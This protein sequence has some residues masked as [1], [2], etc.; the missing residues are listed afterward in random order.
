MATGF[1]PL[2]LFDDRYRICQATID[3]IEAG[4]R[5]IDTAHIYLTED[6]VGKAIDNVTCRGIVKREE[7]FI[8]TKLGRNNHDNLEMWK[9]LEDAQRLGLTKSIG[10]SN[11]NSTYMARILANSKTL[12]AVNQ[13]ETNPTFANLELVAYCQS[14]NIVVTGY[15]PF[16]FLVRRVLNDL[17]FPPTFDDPLLVRLAKKYGVTVSQIV[18][19]W[20]VERGIIPIAASWNKYHIKLNIDIFSFKMSP[21]DVLKM[22]EFDRNVKVYLID[23][24][25]LFEIERQGFYEMEEYIERNNLG[26]YRI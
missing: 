17:S 22:N 4:Y 7:L 21:K 5:H 23:Y 15:S 12:P 11:F 8:T 18:L 24:E 9:G 19:R 13:I 2:P 25:G 20:L 1:Q 3:A 26:Q 16:G 10:I 14:K 6:M